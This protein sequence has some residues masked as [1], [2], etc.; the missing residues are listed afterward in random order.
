MNIQVNWVELNAKTWDFQ[1]FFR[2]SVIHFS[3]VLD[4]RINMSRI[5]LWLFGLGFR[6]PGKK[7]KSKSGQLYRVQ[8]SQLNS[9]PKFFNERLLLIT[10]ESNW[11]TMHYSPGISVVGLA[12]YHPDGFSDTIGVDPD[13]YQR[14]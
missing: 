5:H 7:E 12:S 1:T 3:N 8:V 6:I 4:S 11:Q 10:L 9:T 14:A 13:S 2:L